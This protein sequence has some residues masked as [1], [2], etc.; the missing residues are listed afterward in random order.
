[1]EEQTQQIVVEQGHIVRY[2]QIMNMLHLQLE[3]QQVQIKLG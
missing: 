3:H 2:N 1:M